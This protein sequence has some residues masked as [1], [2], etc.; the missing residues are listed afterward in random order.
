MGT[1][2]GHSYL[3]YTIYI[4]IFVFYLHRSNIGRLLN[5]TEARFGSKKGKGNE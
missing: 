1:P 4:C 2:V 3:A 5:G